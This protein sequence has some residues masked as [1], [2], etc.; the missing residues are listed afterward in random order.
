MAALR[1][2]LVARGFDGGSQVVSGRQSWQNLLDPFDAM[3]EVSETLLHSVLIHRRSTAPAPEG[4]VSL[5][6]VQTGILLLG[7]SKTNAGRRTRGVWG[8]ALSV[9][10]PFVVGLADGPRA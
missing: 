1:F 4:T 5:R 3:I 10:K 6:L 8:A 2:A 7:M 9:R